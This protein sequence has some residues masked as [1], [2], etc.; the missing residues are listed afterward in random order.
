MVESTVNNKV[1]SVTKVSLFIVNYNRELRVGA[2]IKR[3]EKIK[4][5]NGVCEKNEK[6]SEGSGSG[7]EEG[8]KKK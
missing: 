8:Y 3:K 2:D 4:K 5:C 1:Y 6:D 7:F